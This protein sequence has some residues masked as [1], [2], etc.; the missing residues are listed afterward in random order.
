MVRF[1]APMTRK[2]AR[3]VRT[4]GARCGDAGCSGNVMSQEPVLDDLLVSAV[5][6]QG[7]ESEIGGI[8]TSFARIVMSGVGSGMTGIGSGSSIAGAEAPRRQR[9]A[10]LELT[11]AD[12]LA[13]DLQDVVSLMAESLRTPAP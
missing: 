2:P 9:A 1:K 3:V 8:T 11:D 10:V 5:S 7:G 13:T 4:T 6:V 12:Q